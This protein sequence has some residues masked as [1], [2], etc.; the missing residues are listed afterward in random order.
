MII[1]NGLLSYEIMKGY[2]KSKDYIRLLET[3]ALPIVKLKCGEDFIF[4]QD[5]C[6]IHVAK[7]C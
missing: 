3:K 2:Q 6:P 4:K 7:K 1:P 5:N